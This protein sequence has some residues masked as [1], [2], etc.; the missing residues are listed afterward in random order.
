MLATTTA[1]TMPQLS[2]SPS[3]EWFSLVTTEMNL[4][5]STRATVSST[6]DQVGILSRSSGMSEDVTCGCRP[7]CSKSYRQSQVRESPGLIRPHRGQFLT[8]DPTLDMAKAP[9]WTGCE[10]PMTLPSRVGPFGGTGRTPL[11]SPRIRASVPT[12]EIRHWRGGSYHA[13]AVGANGT[14]GRPPGN[15]CQ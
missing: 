12:R 11:V 8:P 5:R 15:A 3:M 6:F 9:S 10:L 2:I 4:T 1:I 7:I 14:P 13:H